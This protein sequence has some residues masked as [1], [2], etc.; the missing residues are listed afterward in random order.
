MRSNTVVCLSA[1]LALALSLTS[2]ASS[3]GGAT[4]P[5]VDKIVVQWRD[6]GLPESQIDCLQEQMAS[7]DASWIDYLAEDYDPAR[8]LPSTYEEMAAA[9]A[10]AFAWCG[11]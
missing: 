6:M 10:Q 11:L 4:N 7:W 1:I 5:N 9:L 3:L 2:C 8:P